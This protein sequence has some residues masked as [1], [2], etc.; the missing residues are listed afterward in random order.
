ME[1]N[2]NTNTQTTPVETTTPVGTGTT[3]V[4]NTAKDNKMSIKKVLTTAGIVTATAAVATAATLI[5]M[6]KRSTVSVDTVAA[7]MNMGNGNF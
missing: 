3:V 2:N 1:N 5:V 6:K 4:V 7:F